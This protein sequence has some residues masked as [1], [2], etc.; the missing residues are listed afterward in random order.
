MVPA[1]ELASTFAILTPKASGKKRITAKF[2]SRELNDADGL[3]AVHVAED[4]DD[5]NNFE[6]S[7]TL[8]DNNNEDDNSI[9]INMNRITRMHW[10]QSVFMLNTAMPF[11]FVLD[12]VCVMNMFGTNVCWS[13]VALCIINKQ[14]GNMRQTLLTVID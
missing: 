6:P 11:D 2:K 9:D 14:W 10:S 4:I 1:H 7:A 8:D 12:I 5:N 13:T 3:L